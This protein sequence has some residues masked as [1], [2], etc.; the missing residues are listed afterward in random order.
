M[1][2]S[3]CQTAPK[4]GKTTTVDSFT[5][6]V[7]DV[8]GSTVCIPLFTIW[9]YVYFFFL[10]FLC[11]A[12]VHVP[13]YYPSAATS[14]PTASQIHSAANMAAF[15]TSK[16]FVLWPQVA[17]LFLLKEMLSKHL[18]KLGFLKAESSV[19]LSISQFRGSLIT[20]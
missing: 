13:V 2:F 19:N 18:K 8:L 7:D 4:E 6:T 1:S 11:H 14:T 20:D 10:A 3:Q 17:V 12:C 16:L 5:C 9:L 15:Q